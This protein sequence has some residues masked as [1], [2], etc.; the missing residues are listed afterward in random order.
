MGL[1]IAQIG[2]RFP[3][4]QFTIVPYGGVGVYYGKNQL[5]YAD[6]L[7]GGASNTVTYTKLMATFDAGV[8]LDFN[9]NQSH[10]FTG[11]IGAEVLTPST[12]SDQLSQ[13]GGALAE[14]PGNESYFQQNMNF[15][16]SVGGRVYAEI[17]AYF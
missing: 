13:S 16:T 8:R 3:A 4:A 10:S 12:I 6:N 11:G 2:Y 14:S 5:T 15:M 1:R 17:G 7:V 9:F